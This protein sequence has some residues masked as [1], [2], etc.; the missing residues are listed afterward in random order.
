MS[1]VFVGIDVSKAHLDVATRPTSAVTR[2]DN[3]EEGI[4]KLVAELSATSPRLVVL[5]A[6]GRLHAALV[7]ALGVAGVPVAVVNPRQARDFAKATGKLAKTDAIDATAL[8]HF[9]EAIQPEPRP[10]PEEG[11]AELEALLVRRRQLV[12]MITAETNRLHACQSRGVRKDIQ[13]HLT[14]MRRRLGDVD[15]DLDD[16][17][18]KSPLWRAKEELLRTV[19]GVGRITAVT[20]L[21]QLPEL[22][23]L[24]RKRI[25][26]LVGLAPL[27]RDSG[28]MRG[29]RVIWGGR[30]PVR[31]ALYMAALVGTRR[32]P[33]LSDVYH[34]LLA[35]G[36]PKKVALTA[37]MRK[38]LTILNAML[39]HSAPWSPMPT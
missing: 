8:A 36:K 9:A 30:A 1:Q 21:A 17:V 25:A 5:E 35:A 27:N 14:W 34:R 29:R 15:R 10:L 38:L 3:D 28:K 13:A 31:A 20:L 24:D 12:E 37:C 18:R 23:T 19:P 16:A 26:A 7:A 39:K 4:A 11:A 32:N 33:A 6:T 22:G 2:F